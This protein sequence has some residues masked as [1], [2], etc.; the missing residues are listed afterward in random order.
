LSGNICVFDADFLRK[1]REKQKIHQIFT[2]S[3][4]GSKAAQA[5]RVIRTIK[6]KL[7]RIFTFKKNTK[8]VDILQDVVS[9]YN[10]SYH[11][12]IK[13]APSSVNKSNEQKIFD[14]V[15][16]KYDYREEYARTE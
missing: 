10:N 14:L 16:N 6:E 3:D 15:Y 5:E 9:A 4:L 1:S 2:R 13:C 11:R 12:I 7:Y 8:Y